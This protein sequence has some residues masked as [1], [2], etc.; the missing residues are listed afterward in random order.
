MG[1]TT[2][3]RERALAR[4]LLTL[5]LAGAAV[6]LW[7]GEAHRQPYPGLSMPRFASAGPATDIVRSLDVDIRVSFAARPDATVAPQRLLGT[8][9]HAAR[10][11]RNNFGDDLGRDGTLA[12]PV[13]SDWDVLLE[14]WDQGRPPRTAVARAHDPRTAAWL[15]DRL[16]ELFEDSSPTAVT[17]RWTRVTRSIP[18]GDVLDRTSESTVEVVL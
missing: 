1:R 11:V 5:L 9:V 2:T 6:T 12:R 18:E 16:G 14:G 15:R 8:P 17:F 10:I 3:R 13:G 4:G 7:L